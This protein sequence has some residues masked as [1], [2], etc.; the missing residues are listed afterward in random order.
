MDHILRAGF[1]TLAAVCDLSAD[2][3]HQDLGVPKLLAGLSVWIFINHPCP[4]RPPPKRLSRGGGLAQVMTSLVFFSIRSIPIDTLS[5]CW[6]SARRK[7]CGSASF[8]A[9]SAP[10]KCVV[11]WASATSATGL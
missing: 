6:Q 11:K 9:M 4:L 8:R 2:Q 7:R 1:H 5:L 3:L 10:T